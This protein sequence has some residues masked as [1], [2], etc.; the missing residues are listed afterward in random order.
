MCHTRDLKWNHFKFSLIFFLSFIYLFVCFFFSLISCA[1]FSGLCVVSPVTWNFVNAVAKRIF[2]SKCKMVN[3]S[4]CMSIFNDRLQAKSTHSRKKKKYTYIYP[5]RSLNLPL[6]LCCC[7]VFLSVYARHIY[8]S[9]WENVAN[10]CARTEN[11][12]SWKAYA[13]HF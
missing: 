2:L 1:I 8:G 6:C 13:L 10:V 11:P 3:L 5:R 9:I 7:A 4:G 12:H